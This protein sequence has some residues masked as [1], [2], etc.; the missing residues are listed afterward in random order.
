MKQVDK[1]FAWL[2][3]RLMVPALLVSTLASTAVF[4]QDPD[5]RARELV[6]QMTLE[7]KIQQL[8]GIRDD[9]HYRFVPP[10]PRL[11]IPSLQI[12][13]GPAGAGPG[14]TRPQ[15]KATALPSPLSLAA[16][17]DPDL[18]KLNGSI[19]GA[20][21]RDIGNGLVEAPTINI[22]RVPQN[23]RTFEG[24]GE[25]PYLVAQIAVSNII[26]IQDHGVLANVK[27]FAANNQ[28]TNRFTVN[29]KVDERALREIYL[30]AFEASIRQGHAASLMCAYPRVNDTYCCEDALLLNEILKKEWG[31]DGFV[32]SDFGAVHSTAATAI[33]GLDLEM[34]TGKYFN[35][36]DLKSAV[37][38]GQVPMS[39]IDDKL[40]RRFRA[41]MRFGIFDHPPSPK[42]IA[43]NENGAKARQLAEE[44]M[45]LLKNDRD[46]LPL[47]AKQLK[48][49]AVIGPAATKAV[50]G[51]GGSSHVAPFYTVDPVAGIKERADGKFFGWQ[52]C[53]SSRI[54]GSGCRRGCAHG[55]RRRYRRAGSSTIAPRE[56]RPAGRGRGCREFANRGG[57]EERIGSLD[58]LG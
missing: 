35:D 17:W 46:V 13:N 40:V 47:R 9:N 8:H 12:T 33:G 28:E 20:E 42:P 56:S 2:P 26:G 19:I 18:A 1:S 58:A 6:R 21:S 23:G 52:R 45:V 43:V 5:A 16:T 38:S 22:A 41:M 54:A 44:G 31:F 24:Y 49:I 34:P 53:Y 57:A 50:T 7:E 51:G 4:A 29:E 14:G 15:A 3:F 11:G 37:E 10:L 48:S 30:P 32:T 27:H 25:D 55:R 36:V 39:V